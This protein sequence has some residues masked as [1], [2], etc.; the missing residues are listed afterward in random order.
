MTVCLHVSTIEPGP[1]RENYLIS[2]LAWHWERAGH[3][4]SYGAASLAGADLGI[5]HVDRTRVFAKD[6][7]GNPKGVPLLNGSVLD[8]SKNLYSTLRVLPGDSWDGPVIIKSVLNCFGGPEWRGAPR[9]LFARMRRKL[10]RRHWRLAQCLPPGDYPI[11]SK[12]SEVPEW[13]WEDPEL[14]VERFLPE[15]E[16]EFYCLRGWIFFG[17]RGYTYRLFSH[18]GVVKIK[19]MVKSEILGEPPPELEAFRAA[20]GFDF[21]KFDYVLVDGRPVILDVNKTPILSAAPDTPR[22]KDLAEGLRS[23]LE[24]V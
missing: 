12:L 17:D 5:L 16:G 11:L 7:P 13:V 14:I 22:V 9:G 23:F 1:L 10:A 19:S 15:R 21:G 4:I 2:R 3:R 20:H 6:L 24:Q 8:I 18:A